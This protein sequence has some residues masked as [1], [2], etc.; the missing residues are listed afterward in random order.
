MTIKIEQL[1]K[2]FAHAQEI[3]GPM[4]YKEPGAGHVLVVFSDGFFHIAKAK[5]CA[6]RAVILATTLRQGTCKKENLQKFYN[7]HPTKDI[8]VFA[9]PHNTVRPFHRYPEQVLAGMGYKN[10]VFTRSDDSWRPPCKVYRVVTTSG[11]ELLGYATAKEC[12]GIM[13]KRL[14]L[15]ANTNAHICYRAKSDGGKSSPM[16]DL[17]NKVRSIEL[18]YEMNNTS[19]IASAAVFF[20]RNNIRAFVFQDPEEMI[21]WETLANY[22]IRGRVR[23]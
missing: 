6:S 5:A 11:V 15:A 20:N 19:V 9:L 17:D 8:R 4:L 13:L 14:R 22:C 21:D 1:K 16:I 12:R 23:V 2:H 10:L 3:V 7:Q 18:V